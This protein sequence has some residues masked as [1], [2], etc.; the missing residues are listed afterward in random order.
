MEENCYSDPTRVQLLGLIATRVLTWEKG[1]AAEFLAKGK[2]KRKR[3]KRN[4][5]KNI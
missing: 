4:E 5:K 2:R 1:Q 3:R